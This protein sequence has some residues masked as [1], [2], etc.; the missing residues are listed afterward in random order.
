VRNHSRKE[1]KG[2]ATEESVL[3]EHTK[4]C[5]F[6]LRG[7]RGKA[8]SSF[9]RKKKKKKARAYDKLFHGAQKQRCAS[10]GPLPS[11]PDGALP[12]SASSGRRE[13]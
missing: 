10:G 12:R 9:K 8:T 3:R 13:T 4:T 1:A 2:T 11:E 7:F 6:P 5:T